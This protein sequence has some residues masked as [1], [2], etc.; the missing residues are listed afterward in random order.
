MVQQI[1]KQMIFGLILFTLLACS[2]ILDKISEEP[3]IFTNPIVAKGHGVGE[4]P[5][6]KIDTTIIYKGKNLTI[7]KGKKK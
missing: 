5:S 4:N 1:I 2:G 7:R 3:I 6:T